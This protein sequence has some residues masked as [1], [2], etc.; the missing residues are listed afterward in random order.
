MLLQRAKKIS[1]AFLFLFVLVS[2]HSFAGSVYPH[3]LMFIN[4]TQ[5]VIHATNADK[6]PYKFSMNPLLEA[7]NGYS[8]PYSFVIPADTIYSHPVTL[9]IN[10]FKDNVM[11]I[12]LSGAVN[13]EIEI[14][15][16]RG[17]YINVK[18]DL[19]YV[20]LLGYRGDWV[21]GYGNRTI[22]GLGCSAYGMKNA[23][24]Q[25]MSFKAGPI[26]QVAT[27]SE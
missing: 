17:N 4:C 26:N 19:R 25:T 12:Y 16:L 22:I 3:E 13:S 14:R 6:S 24:M 23:R 21:P 1:S 27:S 8:E 9:Y 11:N 5:Q 2:Q 18:S 15:L 10:W 7:T 20:S